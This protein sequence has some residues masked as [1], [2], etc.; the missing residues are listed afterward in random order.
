M[1]IILII[2]SLFVIYKIIGLI[3]SRKRAI[4]RAK[5]EFIH[6]KELAKKKGKELSVINDVSD[7]YDAYVFMQ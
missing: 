4:L 7:F 2:I 3:T 1:I 5:E 6:E